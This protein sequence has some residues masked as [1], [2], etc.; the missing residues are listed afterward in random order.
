[1]PEGLDIDDAAAEVGGAVDGGGV[2]P[3]KDDEARLL[4]RDVDVEDGLLEVGVG[5]DFH[6]ERHVLMRLL[7]SVDSMFCILAS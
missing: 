6:S 7:L 1:M 2:A 3:G 5:H 4:E